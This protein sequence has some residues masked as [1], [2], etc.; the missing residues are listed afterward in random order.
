MKKEIINKQLRN[1]KLI[2]L[3][4]KSI[5]VFI[6]TNDQVKVVVSEKGHLLFDWPTREIE[7][8]CG[9]GL[10]GT[11]FENIDHVRNAITNGEFK[12]AFGEGF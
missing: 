8:I 10:S 11:Y 1:G 9:S 4:D 7:V 6:V 2:R 3:D 12:C 5:G